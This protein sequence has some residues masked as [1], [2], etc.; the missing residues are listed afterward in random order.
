MHMENHLP[1]LHLQPA[2]ENSDQNCGVQTLEP[3][4]LKTDLLLR[5]THHFISV[6]VQSTRH[7]SIHL[8]IYP[9]SR[10]FNQTF[11]QPSIHL[12]KVRSIQQAIHPISL[13]SSQP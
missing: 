9:I 8:A 1:F 4:A 7:Q 3:R 2:A 11:D 5:F 10:H 13:S 6:A 12:A